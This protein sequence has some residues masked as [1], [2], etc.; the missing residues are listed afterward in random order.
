MQIDHI[1]PKHQGG[2][3]DD[4]VW[5]NVNEENNLMPSCRSCNHYKRGK[6]LES[7]RNYMKSLHERIERDYISRIAIRYGIINLKP[8]NGKFY[9]EQFNN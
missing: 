7:F 5:K 9:Y 2:Y 4:N 1:H 3:W 8:F 6:G